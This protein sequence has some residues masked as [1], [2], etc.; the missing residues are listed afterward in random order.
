MATSPAAFASIRSTATPLA[1]RDLHTEEIAPLSGKALFC[2]HSK[3]TTPEILR[4]IERRER[5]VLML[6]NGQRTIPDIA[7][8]LHRSELEVTH[9][10]IRL[11]KLGYA[12]YIGQRKI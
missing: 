12:E 6:L 7:R 4:S 1:Q 2:I 9:S 10:L 8:L 11:L 3:A 5:I